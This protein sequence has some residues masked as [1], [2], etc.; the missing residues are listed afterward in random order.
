MILG[1]KKFVYVKNSV[2]TKIAYYFLL[3]VM[4]MKYRVL[5]NQG[6]L[7]NMMMMMM[8]M[9]ILAESGSLMMNSHKRFYDLRLGHF[10]AAP[11]W[12]RFNPIQSHQIKTDLFREDKKEAFG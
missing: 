3:L 6:I 5:K 11:R 12:E 9:T 4:N 7:K 2:I 8:M 10:I 1:K